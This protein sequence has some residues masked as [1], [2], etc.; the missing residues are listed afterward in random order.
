MHIFTD[1]QATLQAL[2]NPHVT[3]KLIEDTITQLNLLGKAVK[4]LSIH[5]I[6]AHKGHA[7]N[8]KADEM[9]RAAEFRTIIDDSINVPVGF[10]KQ[11]LWAACYD[12]WTKEW[13]QLSTCRMTKNILSQ[14]RQK[15]NKKTT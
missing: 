15:Q 5:W 14:T 8:E 10:G 13:Q 12:H 4:S 6:E 7:G 9:A 1:S 11:K 2:N 3:S